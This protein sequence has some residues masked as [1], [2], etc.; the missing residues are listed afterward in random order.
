[1]KQHRLDLAA[2]AAHLAERRRVVDALGPPAD[3]P[4][5]GEFDSWLVGRQV[6][7]LA[8]RGAQAK[9]KDLPGRDD[10][11]DDLEALLTSYRGHELAFS[12]SGPAAAGSPFGRLLEEMAAEWLPTYRA[13]LDGPRDDAAGGPDAWWRAPEVFHTRYAI[14]CAPF[15]AELDRRLTAVLA[16]SDGAPVFDRRFVTGFQ[17]RLLNRFQLAMAWAVETD[18]KAYAAEHGIDPETATAAD[19]TAYLDATFAGADGHHRFFLDFPV[20][21]RWLAHVTALLSEHGRDLVR[22]LRADAAD[23]G[24]AFY[25]GPVTAV[26]N[27]ALGLGDDHAGG[28]SVVLLDVETPDGPHRLVYKPRSVRGEA[29]LQGLLDRLRADGVLG[30]A[31]RP[32]LPRDGYGYEALI[33]SG[34]NHVADRAAAAAVYAEL[35]GYLALFYVLGGGDLHFENIIVADGH[36]YVCDGETILGAVPGERPDATGTVM[37]SVFRTGLIEWPSGR[38]EESSMRLSGYAGGGAYEMPT[39]VP[40]LDE[41]GPSFAASVRHVSGVR[42]DPGAGNRVFLDG[43]IT[44]AEDFAEDVGAGFDAVYRWFARDGEEAVRTVRE[45]FTGSRVRFVNWSTQIYSQL[46]LA[47]RHPRCLMDPVEVD[48]LIDTVRTFPRVWDHDLACPDREAASMWRMDVPLFDTPA[49]TARVTHDHGAEVPL[50]LAA[51]PLDVAAERIRSLT[52]ENRRRQRQYIAAGLAGGDVTS[53]DFVATCVEQAEAVALRL[54]AEARPAGAPWISYVVSRDG[55]EE[56]DIEAELYN[57]TSGVALFL[58]Y[59]NEVSPRP[60]FERTAR[61]ALD[62]A[63]EH[64]T[65]T[66][67]IGAYAGTGG[68]I[69]TLVHLHR[70]WGERDLLD[71]A[72]ALADG[73]APLI[74]SDDRLDVYFGSAG[75]IPVFLGLADAT[76]GHGADLA[77]RCAE[78][79]LKHANS[80]GDALSWPGDEAGAALADLTGFAHGAGGIGWALAML[81]H[82][83]GRASYIDAA[84]RAFAYEDRH[85]DEQVQDWYDLRSSPGGPIWNGRHFANAWCNGAAGIGL[86]R[87]A[88]WDTLGRSDDGLLQGAQRG[89]TATVRNFPRLMND[90]LCHGRSGNAELLL[91]HALLRAEP[92]F[93]VEANLHAQNQWRNLAEARPGPESGFFPGLMLGMAGFGMHSLR[94]ARPELVPSVLLLDPPTRP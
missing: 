44:H 39:S 19:F 93:R 33:P 24:A 70:L 81:G 23:V 18:A 5:L 27:A 32:V 26:R 47:T 63:R 21:G 88:T 65:E 20:L 75:L 7:K 91:R 17:E 15:L 22:R 58:A 79:L 76:G 85:F 62:F 14:V 55:H 59:L 74:D 12:S 13:A 28:R 49:E 57:G 25:G 46:L 86:A 37:D 73:L 30:F 72:V 6:R 89:L 36:A 35:G 29:A 66:G 92:A 77:E 43:E 45:L 4:A 71:Q 41:R 42:V 53:A 83:L 10:G 2:R 69:Y 61:L 40:R 56:V 52:E 94:L 68:L 82:R 87:L 90:S 38:A 3:P 16:E 34:R 64:V 48:L 80:D 51:A 11:Y 67:W 50:R 8:D 84:H 78:H 60:E 31:S 54:C 9:R 1:M